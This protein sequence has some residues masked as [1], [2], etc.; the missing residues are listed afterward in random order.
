MHV[1]IIVLV[2][3][4]AVGDETNNKQKCERKKEMD[5]NY[6]SP[7]CL[8]A[9]G[10]CAPTAACIDHT[11]AHRTI[12]RHFILAR[13]HRSWNFCVKFVFDPVRKVDFRINICKKSA[14]SLER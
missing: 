1:H 6:L 10:R 9:P 5:I 3:T 8:L 11:Y 14:D 13:Y 12:P 4:G 2:N 7:F